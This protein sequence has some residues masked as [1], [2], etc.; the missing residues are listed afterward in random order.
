MMR[1]IASSYYRRNDPAAD[2]GL[3]GRAAGIYQLLLEN[4]R[5]LRL[6]REEWSEVLYEYGAL[7]Q[8]LNMVATRA[9][10]QSGSS[11]PAECRFFLEQARSRIDEFV[12]ANTPN[13]AIASLSESTDK[14]LTATA[15]QPSAPYGGPSGSMYD[16]PAF[17]GEIPSPRQAAMSCLPPLAIALVISFLICKALNLL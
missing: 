10:E 4:R 2:A 3:Y 11:D 6:N 1:M 12:A 7:M 5:S 8:K 15:N 16:R 14:M 13:D 17:N 9:M